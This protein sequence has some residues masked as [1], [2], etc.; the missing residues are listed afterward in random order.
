MANRTKNPQAPRRQRHQDTG[1]SPLSLAWTGL[2]FVI[3]ALIGWLIFAPTHERDD[4]LIFSLDNHPENFAPVDWSNPGPLPDP[5]QDPTTPEPTLATVQTAEASQNPDLGDNPSALTKDG[6]RANDGSLEGV[7]EE[8]LPSGARRIILPKSDPQATNAENNVD[9]VTKLA[10]KTGEDAVIIRIDGSEATSPST[11]RAPKLR[12]LPP[13]ALSSAF[14]G[15]GT[16]GPTPRIAP[17]GRLAAR[18]Y[19]RTFVDEGDKPKIAILVAGLGLDPAL[20]QAA[21]SLPPEVSLAF[22]PYA[23]NL[24]E[25]A[26]DARA[27][28]HELL[29]EIPMESAGVD[30]QQLG[31]AAL[32]NFRSQEDNRKRLD[33]IL[34]RFE[35]FYGATNYLGGTF[36]ANQSAMT[37][38]L[39]ALQGSGLAYVDD[40]GLARGPAQSMA[41]IYGVPDFLLTPQ[42]ADFDGMLA[43]IEARARAKGR[44]MV[45]VYGTPQSLQQLQIWL[46]KLPAKDIVLAPSSALVDNL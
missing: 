45:K 5:V 46:E 44:V 41:M 18:H 35:G 11:P 19:A 4:G 40:T 10:A 13:G 16:Y 37:N 33:W 17:D 12:S 8:T 38:L 6:S 34:S 24:P 2:A 26:A 7:V 31:P 3:L 29:I 25:L 22:A 14:R 39:F 28:G 20:T 1:P 30:E 21:I 32:M 23:K 36:S 27:K 15:I 42:S 43:Q 9:D